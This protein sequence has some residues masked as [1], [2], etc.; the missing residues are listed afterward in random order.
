M[1][2]S[3]LSRGWS[4]WLWAGAASMAQAS[5]I[6][7]QGPYLQLS[8]VFLALSPWSPLCSSTHS[9]QMY[10]D[11]SLFTTHPAASVLVTPRPYCGFCKPPGWRWG[12]VFVTATQSP[13]HVHRR[14]SDQGSG[15]QRRTSDG[16]ATP[17]HL[18]TASALG[19]GPAPGV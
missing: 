13:D 4:T 16:Q 5:Q 1:W 10:L 8:H 19:S 14:T 15:S 11:L 3:S 18:K 6:M 12:D 7:R 17:C 2:S 9:A